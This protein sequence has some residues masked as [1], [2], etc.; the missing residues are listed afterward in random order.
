M[1]LFPLQS[2]R[3]AIAL[4]PTMLNAHMNLGALLHIRVSTSAIVQVPVYVE[5]V[6]LHTQR[7][8][9]SYWGKIEA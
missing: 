8:Q 3:Q 6:E 9:S 1:C 5:Y 2:Y 4:S 7:A